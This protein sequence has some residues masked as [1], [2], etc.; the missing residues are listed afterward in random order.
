MDSDSPP[1]TNDDAIEK[2]E[3]QNSEMDWEQNDRDSTSQV[4]EQREE[5]QAKT[6]ILFSAPDVRYG[7]M[8]GV[9]SQNL[10]SS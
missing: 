7:M 10:E 1:V 5:P 9:L 3:Q 8:Y 4:D 6:L 2:K